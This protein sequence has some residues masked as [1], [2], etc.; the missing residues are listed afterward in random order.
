M[1]S[2]RIAVFR[3][4]WASFQDLSLKFF[5]TS[6]SITKTLDIFAELVSLR[7]LCLYFNHE[8]TTS[9]LNLLLS[10]A[11]RLQRLEHTE[12]GNVYA[13]SSVVSELLENFNTSICLR[14]FSSTVLRLGDSSMGVF[15]LLQKDFSALHSISIQEIKETI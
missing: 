13:D 9:F 7:K 3:A 10:S 2:D 8:N 12:L 6:S 4:M 1:P 14:S 11:H 15:K 5:L